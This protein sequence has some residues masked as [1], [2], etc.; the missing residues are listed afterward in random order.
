[1]GSWE[2]TIVP[3][4][5]LFSDSRF[6][7]LPDAV[8]NWLLR[9][10]ARRDRHGRGSADPDALRIQLGLRSSSNDD[11]VDALAQ[12]ADA[13][14]IDCYEA[15]VE[16]E[17]EGEHRGS[18]EVFYEIA[19]YDLD[20]FSAIRPEDDEAFFDLERFERQPSLWPAPA[21][22]HK[23]ESGALASD[24]TGMP[25]LAMVDVQKHRSPA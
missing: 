10:Y 20:T 11:L 19:N 4:A 17:I 25:H 12:L 5:K 16:G 9:F 3:T 22:R 23:N 24:E 15:Q 18:G 14:L 13:G 2:T 1:M 8:Q 21:P 6:C 7:R